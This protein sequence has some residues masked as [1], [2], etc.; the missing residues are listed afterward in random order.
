M[1]D[2]AAGNPIP[3]ADSCIC[4]TPTHLKQD[5][6]LSEDALDAKIYEFV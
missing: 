3:Y 6:S 2:F 5:A 4:Y 1:L